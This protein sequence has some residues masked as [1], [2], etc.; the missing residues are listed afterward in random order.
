M[1]APPPEEEPVA[2][3]PG[4]ALVDRLGPDDVGQRV[5]VRAASGAPGELGPGGTPLL[6][7]TLGILERISAA[8][9]A[10]RRH[11]GTLVVLP[12]A[13]VVA[14]KRVPPRPERRR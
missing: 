10:V 7:D 6:T 1:S 14:G 12:R 13:T 8:E 5:V 2:H 9:V 3:G 4:A 11:D